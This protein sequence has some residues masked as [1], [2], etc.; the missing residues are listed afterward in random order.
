LPEPQIA[1]ISQIKIA[2]VTQV[3]KRMGYDNHRVKSRNEKMCINLCNRCNL[4]NLW[5]QLF[6]SV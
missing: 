4:C 2:V 6:L 3:L 1:Q 5:F